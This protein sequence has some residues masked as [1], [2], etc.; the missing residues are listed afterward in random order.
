[1]KMIRCRICGETY[2]GTESPTRC[3][4]CGAAELYMV[5]PDGFSASENVVQLTEIE[6]NDL[7]TAIELERS[8]TRFYLAMAAL[9][10]DEPLASAYKRLSRIEAEHCSLFCKLLGAQKPDD[11]GTPEGNP[12][13]WCDAIAESAERETRAAGFYAEAAGRA[14]NERIREVLT[15]VSAVERDHLAFDALAAS[16]AGCA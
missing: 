16:R 5:E 14:T 4:F 10:G 15:A 13:G 12:A 9:A 6:R 7:E 2:L 8:N 1:M 3:P 11:L